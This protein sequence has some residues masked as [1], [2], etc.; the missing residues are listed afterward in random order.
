MT[1]KTLDDKLAALD[2]VKNTLHTLYKNAKDKDIFQRT[3]YKSTLLDIQF[4]LKEIANDLILLD[5]IK[6]WQKT[7]KVNK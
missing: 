1:E 2:F 6:E 5:S 4:T 7:L 3:Q